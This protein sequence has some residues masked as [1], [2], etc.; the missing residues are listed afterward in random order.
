M[1]IIHNTCIDHLRHVSKITYLSLKIEPT[2]SGSQCMV[3]S[4]S[5][6]T[7]GG[8]L[9]ISQ[10]IKSVLFIIL[11][12]LDMSLNITYLS[13]KIEPTCSGSQCMVHSRSCATTGGT[14]IISQP[15]KSVLFIILIILDMSLNITY[16]SLKIEST[17]SG[18]QCMVHS[19]SCAT[20]GGTLIISQPIKSVLFII[21]IILDMSLNITY[22]SLKI[23]PTCSGSQCMV[24]SRSCATTGGT[25]I[26]SQ[27]IKSVASRMVLH[28]SAD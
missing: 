2:C 23:E 21:L 18:S 24:H 26:I 17:C 10:P 5:C 14:L 15:I 28:K 13:L 25:L 6:A 12:I 7:T 20:T 3:H 16:L 9:I 27:P 22:L 11:I 8:T 4:R 1:C 19:R